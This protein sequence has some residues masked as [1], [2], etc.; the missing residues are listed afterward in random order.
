MG[1]L[2]GTL[3]DLLLKIASCEHRADFWKACFENE[4]KG[5]LEVDLVGARYRD[6]ERKWKSLAI[7]VGSCDEWGYDRGNDAQKVLW[8]AL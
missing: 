2:V 4:L 3:K 8:K 7:I 5:L 1:N 6:E